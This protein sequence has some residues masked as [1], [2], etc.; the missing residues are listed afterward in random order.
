MV[1]SMILPQLMIFP[2]ALNKV[3]LGSFCFETCFP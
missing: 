2:E 3:A 1:L